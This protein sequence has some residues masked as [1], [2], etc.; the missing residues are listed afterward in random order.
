M[1]KLFQ[2]TIVITFLQITIFGLLLWWSLYLYYWART[3]DKINVVLNT[4]T[5]LAYNAVG[6][7]LNV[8]EELTPEADPLTDPRKEFACDISYAINS[9][10]YKSI[11]SRKFCN[12][13]AFLSSLTK[14]GDKPCEQFGRLELGWIYYSSVPLGV[15]FKMKDGTV[16]TY[17]GLI[18]FTAKDREKMAYTA[19]RDATIYIVWDDI[20][21]SHEALH[22]FEEHF[23]KKGELIL[24]MKKSD[25]YEGMRIG[26]IH[27][28]GDLEKSMPIFFSSSIISSTTDS[29]RKNALSKQDD[30]PNLLEKTE[31]LETGP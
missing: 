25:L 30:Y 6:L 22:G 5:R 4:R 10:R 20:K 31:N 12:V 27:E 17:P 16:K 26:F 23:V 18:R 9:M 14:F 21:Y 24:H 2:N 7:A 19:Y 11:I 1:R 28:N 13:A 29:K 8:I 15:Y 3:M